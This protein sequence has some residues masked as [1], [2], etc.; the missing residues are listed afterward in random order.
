MRIIDLAPWV[1]E[2]YPLA[3]KV[4][5]ENIGKQCVVKNGRLW[6]S[7]FYNPDYG[8]L[9]EMYIVDGQKCETALEEIPYAP[10]S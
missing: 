8:V 1:R 6:F 4:F 9:A 2:N 10:I 7:N 3:A 5:E